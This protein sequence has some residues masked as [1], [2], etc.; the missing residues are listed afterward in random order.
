MHCSL[1][2]IIPAVCKY[3]VSCTSGSS[4]SLSFSHSAYASQSFPLCSSCH[5]NI[6]KTTREKTRVCSFYNLLFDYIVDTV[7][8]DNADIEHEQLEYY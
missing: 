7:E 8:I 6:E 3:F 1:G 2:H 5:F 4:G